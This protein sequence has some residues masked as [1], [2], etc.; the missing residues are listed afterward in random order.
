MPH[1][2][3]SRNTNAPYFRFTERSVSAFGEPWLSR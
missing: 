2:A 3:L 1:P